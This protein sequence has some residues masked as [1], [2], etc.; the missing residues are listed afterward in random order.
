[1]SSCIVCAGPVSGKRPNDPYACGLCADVLAHM[2]K[3]PRLNPGES[4]RCVPAYSKLADCCQAFVA[5]NP[6]SDNRKKLIGYWYD[7]INVKASGG[8]PDKV[9]CA[10]RWCRRMNPNDGGPCYNCGGPCL[11][12]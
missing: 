5:A 7:V 8:K 2:N 10:N 4:A 1:M 12:A 11:T 9:A 3:L 6:G